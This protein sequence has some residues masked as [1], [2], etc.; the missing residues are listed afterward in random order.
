MKDK[1]LNLKEKEATHTLGGAETRFT[2]LDRYNSPKKWSLFRRFPGLLRSL[3]D[4]T[5]SPQ[6]TFANCQTK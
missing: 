4:R 5:D 3:G 2:L 1:E 6:I